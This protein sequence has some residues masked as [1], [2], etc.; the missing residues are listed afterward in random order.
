MKL[1]LTGT[2]IRRWSKDRL[3]ALWQVVELYANVPEN[4]V[5]YWLRA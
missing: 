1:P 3:Q 5:M 4:T 2:A